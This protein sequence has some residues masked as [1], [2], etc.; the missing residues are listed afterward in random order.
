MM[1]GERQE[2]SIFPKVLLHFVEHSGIWSICRWSHKTQKW[3]PET[4]LDEYGILVKNM[5]RKQQIDVQKFF[6]HSYLRQK[7]KLIII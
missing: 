2:I 1:L 6:L 3:A 5:S 4:V 7:R